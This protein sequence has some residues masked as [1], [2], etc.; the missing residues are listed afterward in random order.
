[1]RANRRVGFGIWLL[2]AAGLLALCQDV[3]LASFTGTI[4][5]VTRNRLA[6]ETTGSNV[7]EFD[8]TGKTKY[9]DGAKKL[10]RS[11]LKPGVRV[12]VEA[13]R[14]LDGAVEAVNVRLERL[15]TR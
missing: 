1:M 7:I 3:P 9:F 6:V 4:R 5:E 14:D 12:T 10:D 13:R 8:C 2:L 15:K 11:A